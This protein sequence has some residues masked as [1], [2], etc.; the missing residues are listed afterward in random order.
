[1]NRISL[2]HTPI[3]DLPQF[4]LRHK[5]IIDPPSFLSHKSIKTHPNM[6][7]VGL[8][9]LPI[10]LQSMDMKAMLMILIHMRTETTPPCKNGL[11]KSVGTW[12][13][14]K[15]IKDFIFLFC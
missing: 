11:T 4:F 14:V 3:I 13:L 15:M 8:G 10:Q 9:E 7:H 5:S 1:M 6:Q 2:P 12:T